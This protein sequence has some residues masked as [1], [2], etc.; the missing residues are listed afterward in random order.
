METI[1]LGRQLS[2]KTN[3]ALAANWRRAACDGLVS[4]AAD[5]GVWWTHR[6]VAGEGQQG[7]GHVGLP[8]LDRDGRIRRRFEGTCY[9]AHD[10]R[11]SFKPPSGVEPQMAFV[12]VSTLPSGAAENCIRRCSHKAEFVGETLASRP[13]LNP[14]AARTLVAAGETSSAAAKS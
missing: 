11:W 3:R 8:R 14:L 4:R 6:R 1:G 10:P 9:R 2:Y 7:V 12:V 13:K 5:P